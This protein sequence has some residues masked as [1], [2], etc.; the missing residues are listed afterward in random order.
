MFKIIATDLDGTLLNS[1]QTVS[2]RT[3][4]I[5]KE[6]CEKGVEF[7]ICTGRMEQSIEFLLPKLPFC[8]YAVTCMGAEVYDL[9]EKKR[10]F[11]APLEEKHT[12]ALAKYA[13]ERNV[14]M[15]IYIDNVLY[16][17]SYDKYSERYLRETTTDALVIEGDV[18]EFL[19]GKKLSKFLM[20]G[21]VEDIKVHFKNVEEMINGEANVCASNERYVEVSNLMAQKDITLNAFVESLGYK[22]DELIVF[23]DSGNDVS[24]LKN[25]GFAVCVGNGWDSAKA[26]SNVICE[27]NDNDGV[28]RTVERLILERLR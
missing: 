15:N 24:M 28:A 19:K 20:I 7:V 23:G 26:A 17:N 22:R 3:V 16:T 12:M 10:V 13:L 27:S 1:K 18:L 14:H 8:H 21:E 2:D 9:Y 25:T 6:A 5:L 4:E 11:F